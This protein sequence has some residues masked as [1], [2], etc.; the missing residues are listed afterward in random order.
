VTE[1]KKSAKYN[2]I[3]DAYLNG[4]IM[5]LCA[6]SAT[7]LVRH[8]S[9]ETWV[10]EHTIVTENG[11][12]CILM[13]YPGADLKAFVKHLHLKSIIGGTKTVALSCKSKYMPMLMKHFYGNDDELVHSVC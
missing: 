11:K 13:E 5:A 7:L 3:I 9:D 2:G 8:F 10:K 12:A 6:D 4:E 1:S